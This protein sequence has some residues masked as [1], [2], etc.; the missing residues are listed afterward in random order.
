MPLNPHTYQFLVGVFASFGSVL[1]GY[2]LGVIAGVV[3]SSSYHE[4]FK[5]LAAQNGAVVSLF[6]GGAFFGAAFAGPAGDY[7][8]RRK[9]ILTG[10]LLFLLGG[11]LQTAAQSINY[12][13]AGRAI[14]GLGVGFLTMIIPVYQGEIA[15]PSIRGRVTGLQQFMLGIGAL[16]A[17]WIS[18]GCFTNY[19]DSRQWRIPL[20]IQMMP[21]VILAALI[22]LF[23]ESP[24]WLI[25]HDRVEDGLRTL[26]SLHAHGN[27]QDPWVQAEFSLIQETIAFEHQHEA[28]SYQELFTSRSSFRRLFLACALQASIQM[29]GVSAIQYFS[30]NIFAQIGISADD[31]LKYQAINSILALIAQAICILT[32]DKFGRRWPLIIGNL[33]NCVT[34]II[35]SILIAK[36]PPSEN[37]SG[38][39]GWGFIIVTWLF[40]ISFS[41]ACGPLSWIIPAEIFDTHTRSKGVSIATMISFAFNTMIGQVTDPAIEGV[42]WRYFLVFVVCNFTNAIF[43]WALLPETKQLP[44]E[45]MNYLFSNAPWIVPGSD[46]STYRAN[47]GVDLERRAAEVR[48]KGAVGGHHERMSES[49]ETAA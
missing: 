28:K 18:W 47:L 30:V 34:F 14:A 39:A 29:T 25:D 7:L 44:L 10:A 8:G 2:D 3:G 21:A 45:E 33:V 46:K 31:A 49:K 23:P 22:L 41:Y 6:T 4:L 40:N 24:R 20:G 32:I 37:A 26:A 42:G 27:T 12:L 36:F 5:P 16:M 38:T 48:E 43:F 1:Y 17:G 13:Y 9:T 15:H 11:A 19:T 35:V